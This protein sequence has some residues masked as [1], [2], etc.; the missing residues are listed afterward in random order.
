LFKVSLKL[1]LGIS[2]TH[3]PTKHRS[4]SDR[5]FADEIREARSRQT[6]NTGSDMTSGTTVMTQQMWH[7]RWQRVGAKSCGAVMAVVMSWMSVWKYNVAVDRIDYQGRYVKR[8][9]DK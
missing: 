1:S 9:K 7:S 3:F 6:T 2:L 8:A 4:S 5:H